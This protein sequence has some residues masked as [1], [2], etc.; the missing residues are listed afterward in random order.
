MKKTVKI[1]R[2]TVMDHVRGDVWFDRQAHRYY[3]VLNGDRLLSIPSVT[4]VIREF[5]APP[6][7]PRKVLQKAG[8]RG[9]D[10]HL[11]CFL[12]DKGRFDEEN[13]FSGYQGYYDGFKAWREEE[14]PA[15]KLVEQPLYDQALDVCGTIDYL[16]Y[17]PNRNVDILTDYKT[18]AP[19]WTHAVQLAAYAM[20]YAGKKWLDILLSPLYLMKNSRYRFPVLKVEE[21]IAAGAK[22]VDFAKAF[23]RKRHSLEGV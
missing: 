9:T 2:G 15:A 22:W 3:H 16:G 13:L 10:V 17:F 6:P 4:Q 8:E 19:D 7:I 23:N 1:I 20:M 14:R 12:T 18:G 11:A 21:Q 5:K